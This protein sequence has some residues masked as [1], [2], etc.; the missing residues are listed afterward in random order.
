MKH[1]IK[2][3]VMAALLSMA[4]LGMSVPALSASAATGSDDECKHY[5]RSISSETTT[6]TN[7]SPQNHEITTTTS[8]K[9]KDC[10]YAWT[11]SVSKPEPH[12]QQS[13]GSLYCVCGY[14]LH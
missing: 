1:K 8:Y 11:E 3:I 12:R 6:Y 4:I 13:S 2:K 9:C 5:N 10:Q 14:Y 7:A